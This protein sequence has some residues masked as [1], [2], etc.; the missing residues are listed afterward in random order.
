MGS[1]VNRT[2]GAQRY[3]GF[4]PPAAAFLASFFA[5]HGGGLNLLL[6]NKVLAITQN[7]SILLAELP[8]R[9]LL[10]LD[11]EFPGSLADLQRLKKEASLVV[12]TSDRPSRFLPHELSMLS[13]FKDLAW[14]HLAMASR[15]AIWTWS[16]LMAAGGPVCAFGASVVLEE[17]FEEEVH[18][19]R[20]P[21]MDRLI[22]PYRHRCVAS[23]CSHL[24]PRWSLDQSIS[25]DPSWDELPRKRI[26]LMTD[27]LSSRDPLTFID[28]RTWRF[29]GHLI[30]ELAVRQSLLSVQ[31][32]WKS[33]RS[34]VVA[35]ALCMKAAFPLADPFEVTLEKFAL[36]SNHFRDPIT[37]LAYF[38]H[39]RLFLR[40]MGIP[41]LIPSDQLSQLCRGLKK[42]K[43]HRRLP[44]LIKDQ[45]R[46]LVKEALA[47]DRV[48]FARFF[49]LS[50]VFLF[51]VHNELFPLQVKGKSSIGDS[52]A[53]HSQ[54]QL[55][56][57]QVTI[58]LKSRK[59]CPDGSAL[60]RK[61][62]CTGDPEIDIWCP[63][64][65]IKAQ[66]E[67]IP[68]EAPRS[69]PMWSFTWS[70]ISKFL[71]DSA[72][73]LFAIAPGWHAFRRGMAQDLLDAGSTLTTIMRAGGWRSSAFLRYLCGS[74]VDAREAL[75]FGLADSDSDRE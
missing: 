32:S 34:G 55:T 33:Y 39:V 9:A 47:I 65:C 19:R 62:C 25:A 11:H 4:E 37:F 70:E 3:L 60:I 51:R 57:S 24:L 18:F 63:V 67:E 27:E 69:R 15:P 44:R 41:V 13:E 71:S 73:K 75:E 40:I 23:G 7:R 31:K 29:P 45:V 53:W 17:V 61:C 68:A 42:K 74:T 1:S 66:I 54:I 56:D 2:W 59:N 58:H 30:L 52:E 12:G 22:T 16:E 21:G 50:R 20:L 6:T 28:P 35:Y 8:D 64:H 5:Q 43:T 38:S 26:K 48:D 10:Q 72:Q 46:L 49:I 36:F 14:T